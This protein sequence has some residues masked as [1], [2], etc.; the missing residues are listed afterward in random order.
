MYFVHILCDLGVLNSVFIRAGMGDKIKYSSEYSQYL[1]FRNQNMSI[2]VKHKSDLMCLLPTSIIVTHHVRF[3]T[4]FILTNSESQVL[5][6]LVLMGL[7]FG[8]EKQV[9]KKVVLQEPS[10]IINEKIDTIVG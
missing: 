9:L 5:K 8:L 10:G 1:A 2:L 6:T 7:D 3:S 4:E